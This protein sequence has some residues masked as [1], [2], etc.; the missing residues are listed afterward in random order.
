[1]VSA[2]AAGWVHV[3]SGSALRA[4]RLLLLESG[5]KLIQ[6]EHPTIRTVEV[7]GHTMWLGWIMLAALIY[8]AIPPLV[9]GRM[10]KPLSDELHDK[11]LQVSATVNKGDWLSVGRRGSGNYWPGIRIVV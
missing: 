4:R 2:R 5:I 3:R 9:L 7:F 8:S 10:K 11:A 6:A 1:M